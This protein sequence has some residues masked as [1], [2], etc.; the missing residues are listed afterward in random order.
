MVT[1]N[2]GPQS[3]HVLGLYY[4]D[5]QLWVSLNLEFNPLFLSHLITG[6]LNYAQI[7]EN[8]CVEANVVNRAI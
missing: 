7:G 5:I 2:Y 3:L 1:L 4:V 8:I 6:L